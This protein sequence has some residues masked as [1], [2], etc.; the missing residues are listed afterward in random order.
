MWV[1][2]CF[3]DGFNNWKHGDPP[4]SVTVMWLHFPL[5][6]S[7]LTEFISGTGDKD[8]GTR[9]IAATVFK[10]RPIGGEAADNWPF[11]VTCS[12]ELTLN[13]SPACSVKQQ[14]PP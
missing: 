9:G 4:Q 5:T 11:K 13:G 3:S 1:T 14:Q 6:L 2:V 12:V 10:Q 7:L 8:E